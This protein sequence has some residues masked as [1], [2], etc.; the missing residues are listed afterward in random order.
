M[1]TEACN[2]HCWVVDSGG[3]SQCVPQLFEHGDGYLG[4]IGA[5]RR[6]TSS[7][8]TNKTM[9]TPSMC[10]PMYC[11]SDCLVRSRNTSSNTTVKSGRVS[12]HPCGNPLCNRTQ[13]GAAMPGAPN[14]TARSRARL[15]RPS[16]SIEAPSSPVLTKC[17]SCGHSI[18]F[19]TWAITLPVKAR[20]A[21]TW[22][23]IQSPKALWE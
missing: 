11:Y 21:D 17:I 13:S 6:Y 14:R 12:G 20:M 2:D 5:A 19:T 15:T 7:A 1:P 8:N 4:G 10:N 18:D 23:E 22:P 9:R 3:M 16:T